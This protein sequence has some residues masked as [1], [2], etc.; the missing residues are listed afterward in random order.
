M[1]YF[2]ALDWLPGYIMTSNGQVIG[3]CGEMNQAWN[4]D[5]DGYLMVGPRLNGKQKWL[6]VNRLVCE[7][8]HGPPPTVKHVAA[9]LNGFKQDNYADNLEWKTPRGNFL[10]Q[11][12]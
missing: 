11:V 12:S 6:R 1:I 10:D 5:S 2:A 3:P 8:F 9:H 4:R 7:A